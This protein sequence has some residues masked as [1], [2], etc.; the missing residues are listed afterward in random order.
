M[1]ERINMSIKKELVT[2]ALILVGFN[3]YAQQDNFDYQYALIE[4]VKQKNL[5]NLPGAVEL[6]QMVLEENDS[7]AV[8]HYEIGTLYAATGNLQK[9][10]NHLERAYEIDQSVKWYFNAYVDVLLVQEEFRRAKKI[11]RKRIKSDFDNKDLLYRLANVYYL[12]ERSRKAIRVLKKMEDRWGL[13]EKITLLKANIYEAKG[14]FKKALNELEKV[15]ELV[16]ESLEM[17]VVAAELALSSNDKEL[18]ADY[19]E[20]VLDLDSMNIYALTNLTDYYRGKG[21]MRKSFLYLNKSFESDKIDYDRKIAILSLYVSDENLV[22]KQERAIREL[23]QT[24]IRKYRGNDEIHLIA[25]DFFIGLRDYNEALSAIKPL[26]NQSEKRYNLWRQGL[27]LANTTDKHEQMLVIADEACKLFPDS[28][29]LIYLKGIAEWELDEY[30]KLINTFS[31]KLI[32]ISHDRSIASQMKMMVAESYQELERYDKSDSLFRSIIREEPEN[33]LVMNNFSY[34]LSERGE[35]LEEAEEYSRMAIRN[36]PE[37]GTFLDTYAW[38]LFQL[39]NYSEAEKFIM[40][41][42]EHGGRDSPVINE[43]A[44]DIHKKMGNIELARIFYQKAMILGGDKNNLIEKLEKLG[45]I[46]ED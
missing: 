41:A 8:A 39:G 19:Y 3:L 23:I 11:V 13:S 40:K 21:E 27:L 1:I 7:V 25:T 43:H 26:L 35:F 37:N 17:R 30:E 45:H 36:N 15:I 14:D 18:A 31:N 46:Y 20:S 10:S 38:I 2:L 6:Y 9:A 16:P 42:L 34:Y 29:E 5:G 12:A 33:Y 32:S 4:A 22:R 44:G 24:M 28:L